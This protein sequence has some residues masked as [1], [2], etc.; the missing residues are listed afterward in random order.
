MPGRNAGIVGPPRRLR[1]V[2]A[3]EPLHSFVRKAAA[4]PDPAKTSPLR[5]VPRARSVGAHGRNEAL[6]L[7]SLMAKALI[8][9]PIVVAAALAAGTVAPTYA[10]TMSVRLALIQ[11]SSSRPTRLITSVSARLWRSPSSA[12]ALQP[13]QRWP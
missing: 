4:R 1:T 3:D 13:S 8:S 2:R 7:A 11:T 6:I 10:Q 12:T 5:A 9:L